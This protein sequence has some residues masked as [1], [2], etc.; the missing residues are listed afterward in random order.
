MTGLWLVGGATVVALVVWVS[1]RRTVTVP[2][3]IDLA[4]TEETF[5]AHVS[6]QGVEVNEGDAVLV[7]KAPSRIAIGATQHLTST[8]TVSQAS[9]PRRLLVRVL[10][11]SGITDLYEVGFEG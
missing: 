9:W 5:H 3:E 2:C 4:A 10:G 6:L 8:A 7:H 11:T 1:W